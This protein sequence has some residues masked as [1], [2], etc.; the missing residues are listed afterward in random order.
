MAVQLAKLAKRLFQCYLEHTPEHQLSA[1]CQLSRLSTV[2]VCLLIVF[3]LIDTQSGHHS[4]EETI[5]CLAAPSP[6]TGSH[7]M[8][9]T[10]QVARLLR[11]GMPC[12]ICYLM[13]SL[14]RLQLKPT[15]HSM[16]K[17]PPADRGLPSAVPHPLRTYLA[18][19]PV[20]IRGQLAKLV[21]RCS[22]KPVKQNLAQ[23]DL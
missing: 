4:G 8:Q 15:A 10:L 20:L 18:G 13:Q 7:A 11:L 21:P 17:R 12:C 3:G 6:L 23:I 14:D 5:A 1:D 2:E 16:T 9:C 19:A 22:P